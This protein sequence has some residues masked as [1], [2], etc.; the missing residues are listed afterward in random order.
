MIII[1]HYF[2][3]CFSGCYQGYEII[4][5]RIKHLTPLEQSKGIF[6]YYIEIFFVIGIIKLRGDF[7]NNT[8]VLMVNFLK[9]VNYDI[10]FDD[11]SMTIVKYKDDPWNHFNKFIAKPDGVYN[12]VEVQMGGY[13]EKKRVSCGNFETACFLTLALFI[14]RNKSSMQEDLLLEMKQYTKTILNNA[15]DYWRGQF[16]IDELISLLK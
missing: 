2:A 8:I 3:V 14:S 12:Y 5:N 11:T 9:S 6:V 13:D 4:H 7:M 1:L 16:I 15:S 10:A